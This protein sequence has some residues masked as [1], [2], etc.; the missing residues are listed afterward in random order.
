MAESHHLFSEKSFIFDIWLG[1]EYASK[2]YLQK[3]AGLEVYGQC[4][5]L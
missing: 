4:T 3:W 5:V 2:K 1:S